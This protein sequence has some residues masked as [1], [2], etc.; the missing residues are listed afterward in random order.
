MSAVEYV[1][2]PDF[3][4]EWAKDWDLLM[5]SEKAD[6]LL[7]GSAV[8]EYDAQSEIGKRI[9]KFEIGS[10][11]WTDYKIEIWAY[12]LESVDR[13]FGILK[14]AGWKMSFFD[15]DVS[16]GKLKGAGFRLTV[17]V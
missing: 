13:L 10:S 17:W 1:A 6:I 9:Q 11:S 12:S 8:K 3:Y 2:K 14:N 4:P 16:E 5:P 15:V 7:I